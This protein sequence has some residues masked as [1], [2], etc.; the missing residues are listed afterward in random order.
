MRTW[1]EEDPEEAHLHHAYEA[2]N[3]EAHVKGATRRLPQETQPAV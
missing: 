2:K 3:L 1:K